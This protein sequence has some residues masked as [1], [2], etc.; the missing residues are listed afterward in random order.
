L[1]VSGYAKS[2]VWSTKENLEQITHQLAIYDF[3]RRR[4]S[5]SFHV[6]HVTITSVVDFRGLQSLVD[7][8]PEVGC[9]AGMPGKISSPGVYDGL[10]FNCGTNCVFSRDMTELLGQRF[11]PDS[12]HNSVPQDVNVAWMLKDVGRI[13]LPFFSFTKPRNPNKDL[14]N[15]DAITRSMLDAGHYHFRVKTTSEQAGLG[16]RGD[17]DPW[18]M[19]EVMRAILNHAPPPSAAVNLQRGVLHSLNT[20]SG[21]S[22]A[23]YEE[24]FFDKPRDFALSDEEAETLFPDLRAAN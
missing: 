3:L 2:G 10:T 5:G 14:G 23:A 20:A 17:V 8:L 21:E 18:I 24:H 13:P 4:Y 15:I 6:V 22:M 1:D 7:S 19:F 12:P 16:A 11:D 9:Y